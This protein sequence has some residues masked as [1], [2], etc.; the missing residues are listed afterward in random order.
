MIPTYSIASSVDYLLRYAREAR[1]DI[2]GRAMQ[3]WKLVVKKMNDDDAHASRS[4]C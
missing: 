2:V 1:W 4:W 3:S